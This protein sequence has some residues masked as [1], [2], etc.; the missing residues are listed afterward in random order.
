MKSYYVYM[1]KCSDDSFYVGFTN[2]LERRLNEHNYGL[3]IGSYTYYRRPLT[4]VWFEVFSNPLD[5]IKFEKQL[6]GWS[7][8]KKQALIDNDWDKIVQYSKNYTEYGK[9]E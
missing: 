1:L 8:R 7:R 9:N 3:N 4:L 6:K 2:N 5:G